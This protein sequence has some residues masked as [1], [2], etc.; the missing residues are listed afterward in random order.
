MLKIFDKNKYTLKKVAVY[1]GLFLVTFYSLFYMVNMD[2]T[3]SEVSTSQEDVAKRSEIAEEIKKRVGS[4][5]VGLTSFADWSKVHGLSSVD[6]YE[7]D[8]DGDGLLN[9]QEY[10]HL[11]DPTMAD[12]DNDGYS[13]RQEIING[14]DPDDDGKSRLMTLIQIDKIGVEAP[15]VWSSSENE[16]DMLKDLENGLSHYNG[17]ASPRQE[18]N[19]IISGHSSN[20]F[21]AKG[22]YNHIFKDLNDL[23]NGDIVTVKT[24]QKNG[25]ILTY[26][27]KINDKFVAW[28]DD[29]RIF[30]S[31]EGATLTLS[32]CWPLGTTLKR[33]I[34]KA[35]LI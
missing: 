33:V 18:G 16:K 4:D 32:T 5:Q 31:S 27:Y 35:D 24:I 30:A 10:L 14:Y 15:M 1:C 3:P 12:S 20:Y 7:S 9:Y 6:D 28:P 21:W 34:V 23:E 19:M 22:G 2:F 26:Q 11:T 17:T 25:R 29:E 13:D 8:F